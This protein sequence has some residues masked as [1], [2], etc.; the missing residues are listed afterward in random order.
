M[1]RT[2]R[3]YGKLNI[4]QQGKALALLRSGVT[5]QAVA[6]QLGVSKNTIAGLWARRGE[7]V[8]RPDPTTLFERCDAL[9]RKLDAVLAETVGVGRIVVEKKS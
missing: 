7:P 6:E 1:S 9:H 3:G 5:Q 8:H 2:T 4:T